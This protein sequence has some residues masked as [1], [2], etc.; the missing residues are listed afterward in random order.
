MK[1]LK[2]AKKLL[3]CFSIFILLGSSTA[4]L[5]LMGINGMKNEIREMYHHNFIAGQAMGD[6]RESFQKELYHFRPIF[7]ELILVCF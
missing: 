7:F 2:I 6:I 4:L 3:V 5:G 1:N